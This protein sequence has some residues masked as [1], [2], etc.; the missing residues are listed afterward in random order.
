MPVNSRGLWS[1][2]GAA[3]ASRFVRLLPP[4]AAMFAGLP[5]SSSDRRNGKA[6]F[7]HLLLHTARRWGWCSLRS[8]NLLGD[9][10]REHRESAA[11]VVVARTGSRAAVLRRSEPTC[12]SPVSD[13]K[14]GG[15]LVRSAASGSEQQTE[16][17]RRHSLRMALLAPLAE[18]G[19]CWPLP[20]SLAR[21]RKACLLARSSRA[22]A[23]QPGSVRRRAIADA[24]HS[25]AV[26]YTH[27][28]G[29][30]LEGKCAE[31]HDHQQDQDRTDNHIGRN[32]RPALR[33][34][35]PP[36]RGET[37]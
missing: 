11:A 37:R 23:R 29:R 3:R 25:I 36:C 10:R 12:S 31:Q 22:A 1:Y 18:A 32:N 30:R 35:V 20:S 26:R 6:L 7:R 4:L 33:A 15:F 21:R 24:R 5:P 19:A 17:K 9:R 27:A 14:V 2:F 34:A 16:E 13:D 28:A 8:R